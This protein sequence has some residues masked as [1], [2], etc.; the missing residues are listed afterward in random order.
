MRLLKPK[1]EITVTYVTRTKA[2]ITVT[3]VTR[4]K[5]E[6]KRVIAYPTEKRNIYRIELS[7]NQYIE[8]EVKL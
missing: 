6:T 3:Y 1:A 4:T 5:T 7:W 8:V 2:E